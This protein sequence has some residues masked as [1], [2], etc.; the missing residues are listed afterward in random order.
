MTRFSIRSRRLVGMGLAGTL[1]VFTI[2]CGDDSNDDEANAEYAAFCDA[3]LEV[4][5]AVGVEEPDPEAI[6]AAFS[7]LAEATPES[8]QAIV[9]QTI[10]AAQTM[11]QSEGEDSAAFDEAYPQLIQVVRDN[12]GFGELDVIAK[13]YE[14]SGVPDEV[15][16]GPTVVALTNEATDEFHEAVFIRKND[17][18]TRSAEELL[19]LPEGEAD[20]VTTFEGVA[21]AA[22]GEEA[23]AVIDLEAGDYV[24]LCFL[25][26]GATPEAMATME[27][28]GEEPDGAPHFTE[29]MVTEFTVT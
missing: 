20:E 11:L 6:E 14:Y 13:S 7:A 2:A 29:G 16:G 9:D 23:F 12:C 25:P 28:T 5:A 10:G 27:E 15:D 3:E 26:V 17:G 21:F 8:S 18:E 22:P 19:E 24:M 4:E 1:A